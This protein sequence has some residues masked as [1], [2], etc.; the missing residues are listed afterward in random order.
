MWNEIG[1]LLL[2][3][4][5]IFCEEINP[6]H[7]VLDCPK[8]HNTINGRNYTFRLGGIKKIDIQGRREKM[9]AKKCVAVPPDDDE[10]WNT[11]SSLDYVVMHNKIISTNK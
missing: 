8:L 1:V 3:Q 9:S 6:Y 4:T 10:D 11:L 7:Y 5:V 2:M